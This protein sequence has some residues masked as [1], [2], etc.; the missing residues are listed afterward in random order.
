VPSRSVKEEVSNNAVSVCAL[1]SLLFWAF[2]VG[3]LDHKPNL[4]MAKDRSSAAKF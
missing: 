1:L 2:D 4:V 3:E